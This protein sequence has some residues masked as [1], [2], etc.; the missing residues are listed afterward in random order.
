[1]SDATELTPTSGNGADVHP[2]D[3]LTGGAF[4]AQTSGERAACLRAWLASDPSAEQLQEV[5]KELGNRDKGATRLLRERLDDMRRAQDQ[6]LIVG[7]WAASAQA[8]L[9]APHFSAEQAALWQRDAAKAGAPLSREPL[10]GLKAQLLERAKGIEELQHKVQ[11]QREVAVLLAQRIEVLSTKPWK[12]AEAALDGLQADVTQWRQQ[13]L[14]LRSDA[15]WGCVPERFT[16]TLE[17]SEAQLLLVWQAFLDALAVTKLAAE[18][19]SAAL[20]AVPVWAD[21]IRVA[22]GMPSELAAPAAAAKPDP[23]AKQH[24][25]QAALQPLLQSLADAAPQDKA[26]AI[27]QVRSALKQHGRWLDAAF[28]GQ[29]H[30][31]LLAAGDALG[32]QP[33]QAD[34]LRQQLIEQAVALTQNPQGGRKLQDA[35]R[36]LRDQWRQIDQGAAPNHGLWKKF[37]EACTQVHL[38]VQQWLGKVRAESTQHKAGRQA[39]IDEV[40][41]WAQTPVSDWKEAARA[42]RQF[43][44]R[45]RDAGHVGEK[46]FAELQTAWK[47]AIHAA[48]APLRAAQKESIAQREA[49]ISQVKALHDA[50]GLAVDAIKT[51][52]QQWQAL[53]QGVPLERKLE[54]KL[55]D[56]F[57]A[58]VDA[59]FQ[60]KSA[61]RSR[62]PAQ[63]LS[64]HDR[65]VLDAA[66]A[67]QAA[68][69]SGDAQQI[70]AAL[71]ALEAARQQAPQNDQPAQATPA[72][73]QDAAAVATPAASAER[74]VIA[75]RGDDRP[76]AKKEAA[77][78]PQA[79]RDSRG[80]GKERRP[81]QRPP[82]AD[83]AERGPRLSDAAFRAQRDAVDAAQHALRKLTA[84]AHGEAVGQLLQAWAQRDAAALPSGQELGKLPAAARNSWSQALADAPKGDAAQ[85]LL[86]LEVAADVPTPAEQHSQRR[87]LQLQLL[88]QRN[89]AMP[90]ETWTQDVAAVLATAHGEATARRLQNV[91]KAL[92]RK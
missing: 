89:A 84:Q 25:A 22:R 9:Q 78:H 39:L 29:V 86:R 1:M 67:L 10:A 28:A 21:E 33:Q 73:G 57:R 82:R 43:G 83:R 64:A 51:L 70:R 12:D 37:D 36:H 5:M 45:W 8:L 3:S 27:A 44:Q 46:A 80:G 65:A 52:Q 2:L 71:T 42:L 49:L 23:A 54:Q 24:A 26:A 58:P 56:A 38:Q 50:P 15:G 11:V 6:D 55:W 40:K 16:N 81:D 31:Q 30:E 85:T 90:Q 75:V 61:E 20:P 17:T 53:A 60:R 48:E 69:A 76:G 35:L 88:T 91:L 77:P 7:E 32:W 92:L 59:L 19:A 87:M 4:S 72:A 68:N 34:T 63:A 18:D 74:P 13:A 79:R 41:A 47:E 66:Q 14:S 62:A